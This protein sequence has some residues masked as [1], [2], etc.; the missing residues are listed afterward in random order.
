MH[1]LPVEISA[2]ALLDYKKLVAHRIIDDARDQHTIL[3]CLD[4]SG[5]ML[6]PQGYAE[7]RKAV[8]EVGGAIERIDI[9]AIF[10]IE[11]VACSFL[12]VDAMPW[13]NGMQALDDQ[14]F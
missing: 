9:P 8:S 6:K 5:A 12:T 13:K 2:F 3:V 4:S 1:L 14:L 11:M 7:N 10:T